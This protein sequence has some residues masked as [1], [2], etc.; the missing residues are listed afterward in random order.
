MRRV[1]TLYAEAL[2]R[3]VTGQGH[4]ARHWDVAQAARALRSSARPLRRFS[5]RS[6]R[7]AQS[8]PDP[9]SSACRS[10]PEALER[11][12]EDGQLEVRLRDSRRRSVDAGAGEHRL[13]LDELRAH[14][15]RRTTTG[16][17]P[18]RTRA[19]AGSAQ[20]PFEAR[21]GGLRAVGRAAQ[22]RLAPAGRR[23]RRFSTRPAL[24]QPAERQRRDLARAQLRD[25]TLRGRPGVR[26]RPAGPPTPAGSKCA[27]TS[28]MTGRIIGRLPVLSY[29][30]WANRRGDAPGGA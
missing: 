18:G 19:R 13:P 4:G 11:P 22:G 23:R 8:R 26:S 20:R 3:A 12:H 21:E 27:H 17:P 29:T 14:R 9:A 30:S 2:P 10:G 25:E 7:P 28:T 15:A 5:R 6:K 16:P 1:S 24:Q